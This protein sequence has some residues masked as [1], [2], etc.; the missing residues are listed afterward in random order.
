[1]PA[2][3]M[4]GLDQK[5]KLAIGWGRGG[6]VSGIST[7]GAAFRAFTG[8]AAR[9]SGFRPAFALLPAGFERRAFACRAPLRFAL[10]ALRTLPTDFRDARAFAMT[11]YATVGRVCRQPRR[12]L[13]CIV[14]PSNFAWAF[15]AR[16][17]AR[18][19]ALV[20]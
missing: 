8:F 20:P 1:M 15:L 16:R 10:P 18:V 5:V 9:A 11:A 13:G 6:G 17:R 3:S 12:A 4:R 14:P 19:H 2:F 7:T